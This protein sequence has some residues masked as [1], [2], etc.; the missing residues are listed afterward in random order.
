MAIKLYLYFYILYCYISNYKGGVAPA[1]SRFGSFKPLFGILN[2]PKL[3]PLMW[4]PLTFEFEM[5][6]N[7]TDPIIQPSKGTG[8]TDFKA[9]NTSSTWSISDVR[10]LCDVVTID[11]ALQN[12]YAEHVLSGKALPINYGTYITQYQLISGGDIT[13]NV[14]RALSRLKSVFLSFDNAHNDT[15]NSQAAHIC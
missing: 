11:S 13:V 14:T 1:S 2:Q 8:A 15:T 5:T 9:E 12:S 6:N 10:I 4:C 3:I 7:A